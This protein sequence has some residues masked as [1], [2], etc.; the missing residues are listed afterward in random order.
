MKKVKMFDC[1][2]MPEEVRTIFFEYHQ[3]GNDILV[4]HY[5]YAENEYCS[6][7]EFDKLNISEDKIAQKEIEDGDVYY[8]LLGKDVVS[9]WLVENGAKI[10]D[11]V[12]IKHWW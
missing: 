3:K 12:V 1:Q 8:N 10:H 4:E 11:E 7:K 5:V 2:D 9:D 6:V